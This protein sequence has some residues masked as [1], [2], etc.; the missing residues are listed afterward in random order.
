MTQSTWGFG[1]WGM[2]PWGLGLGGA[3]ASTYLQAAIAVRENVVRLYLTVELEFTG[4]FG[5]NDA[6]DATHYVI[7]PIAGT[8]GRDG[9]PCRPVIA[10]LAENVDDAGHPG[11]V[12]DVTVDR[13][14]SSFSAQYNVAVSNLVSL[15]P[16]VLNPSNASATFFGSYMPAADLS[17]DGS[18]PTRDF[19]HP[20]TLTAELDPLPEAGSEDILGTIPIDSTGDYAVDEGSVN[21]AKRVF[22]R[23]LTTKNKFLHAKGYGA[24]APNFLKMLARAATRQ[25]F[26]AEAEAQIRQEPDVAAAVVRVVA[27]TLQPDL[28]RFQV[29]VKPKVGRPVKVDVPFQAV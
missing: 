27:D 9:L 2:I 14:F 29:L 24:S 28:G 4:L 10:V 17:I 7:T 21:L 13:P 25:S 22:R 11:T 8:I 1:P 3:P 16:V 15:D 5:P 18:L 20:D 12:V 6:G 26:A 19:A 23:L